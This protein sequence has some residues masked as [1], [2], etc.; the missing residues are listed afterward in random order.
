[1]TAFNTFFSDGLIV[2]GIV[3]VLSLS[4]ISEDIWMTRQLFNKAKAL[5]IFPSKDVIR[6]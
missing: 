3:A 1:M 6:Q 5:R 2:R 4:V